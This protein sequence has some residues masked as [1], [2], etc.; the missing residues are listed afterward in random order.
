MSGTSASLHGTVLRRHFESLSSLFWRVEI[1]LV[2]M[3][4]VLLLAL[5][6][7]VIFGLLFACVEAILGG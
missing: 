5:C 2:F 3:P 7:G 1:R 4:E 6:E